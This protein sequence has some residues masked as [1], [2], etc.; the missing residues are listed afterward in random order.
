MTSTQ[1]IA[2][3]GVYLIS[4][5]GC[6]VSLILI[7]KKLPSRVKQLLYISVAILLYLP[8]KTTPDKDYLS[9]AFLTAIYDGLSHGPE[10]MQRSGLVVVGAVIIS[11]ALTLLISVKSSSKIT[12]ESQYSTKQPQDTHK[13]PII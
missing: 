11:I 9:P 12:K 8:W 6:L 2:A 5:A 10:A 4:A 1:Y 3:W 13:E 7:T